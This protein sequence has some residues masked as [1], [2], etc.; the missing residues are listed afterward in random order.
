M[1]IRKSPRATLF[2]LVAATS[3]TL[4]CAALAH[5]ESE[6]ADEGRD[7]DYAN[8]E[9]HEFG[10]AADPKA[11]TRTIVVTMSDQMRFSPDT[12]ELEAGE[13]VKFEVHNDGALMHEM[14]L[15]TTDELAEH[16]AMMKKFPGME[17]DEPYMAHVPPSKKMSMGWQFTK[18]GDY[19]YACLVPGHMEAGMQ[20]KITA[21]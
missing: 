15:G 8:A 18:P 7:I 9:E 14:V 17:H 16:A 13:V 21:R 6:H 10:K 19:Y 11:A 3:L 4:P 5:S 20:G 2:A 1:T 12:V